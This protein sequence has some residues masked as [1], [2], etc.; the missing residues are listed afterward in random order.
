MRL[1]IS[2]LLLLLLS[3]SGLA[4]PP[5]IPSLAWQPRS[6]WINV[7]AD[8]TPAAV[9]NGRADDTAAIQ[10]AL[11]RK[12]DGKTVYLLPGAYRITKTLVLQGPAVGCLVVGHGPN[13]ED[14]IRPPNDEQDPHSHGSQRRRK[15]RTKPHGA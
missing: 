12:V 4:E 5:E 14:P 1:T 3:T 7:R 2:L 15:G 8:V 10:T 9:G 11:D 6:D 13:G